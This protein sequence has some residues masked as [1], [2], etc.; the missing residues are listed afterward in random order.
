MFIS[1]CGEDY[2][3]AQSERESEFTVNE[4]AIK[5][6]TASA[7]IHERIDIASSSSFRLFFPLL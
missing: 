7:V 2:N 3:D 4:R 5:T 6:G 1:L